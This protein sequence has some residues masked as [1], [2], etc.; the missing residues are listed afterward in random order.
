MLQGLSAVSFTRSVNFSRNRFMSP[1]EC[2][3][4]WCGVT[5]SPS[6]G[7]NGGPLI[8]SFLASWSFCDCAGVPCG[9]G[10][11]SLV[12][13]S[14]WSMP[15]CECDASWCGV[16]TFSS[17]GPNGGPLIGSFL[18]SWSFCDCAGDP[19]GDGGVP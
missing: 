1:C 19:C 2:D 17:T 6:T 12:V 7:P 8:E 18:A 3:A 5:T 16:T 15:P 4:S 14:C 9:D 10:G 13:A 11:G